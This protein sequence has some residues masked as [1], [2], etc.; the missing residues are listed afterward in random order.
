MENLLE[1]IILQKI[2]FNKTN[3]IN[4]EIKIPKIKR[5]TLPFRK[6]KQKAMTILKKIVKKQALLQ[7]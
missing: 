1:I 3:N 4:H 6:N 5:E 2:H 7:L